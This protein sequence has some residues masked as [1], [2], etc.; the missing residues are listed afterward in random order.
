M[1]TE[2]SQATAA[3]TAILVAADELRRVMGTLIEPHGITLQQYHVLRIL[4]D[5]HPEPLTTRALGE[6]LVERTPGTTRLLERLER[7]RLVRRERPAANRRIV[8]C[9]IEPAGLDML[10]QAERQGDR[11]D[12]AIARVLSPDQLGA[13]TGALAAL[14]ALNI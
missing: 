6:R 14:R 10:R 1:T 2:E 3:R 11:L 5:A 7:K 4:R 13:L 8:H 9:R 12:D